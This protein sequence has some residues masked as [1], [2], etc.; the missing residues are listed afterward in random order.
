MLIWV[1]GCVTG[2]RLVTRYHL[3]I[4]PSGVRGVEA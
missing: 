4:I 3:R 1:S 2:V